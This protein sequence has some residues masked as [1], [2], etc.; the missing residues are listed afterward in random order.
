LF[1]VL[2]QNISVR[3]GVDSMYHAI[4]LFSESRR[5]RQSALEAAMG[6]KNLR[7]KIPLSPA[8]FG[9]IRANPALRCA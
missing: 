2:F 8:R 1:R 3:F 5:A 4:A 6:E 9:S 7:E